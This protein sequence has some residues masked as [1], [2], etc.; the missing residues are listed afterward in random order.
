MPRR[1]SGD[2]DGKTE[3]SEV[4]RTI[5]T[6]VGSSIVSALVT[7]MVMDFL[8]PS[9]AEAQRN[10]LQV[11]GIE[12]VGFDGR[13]WGYFGLTH[14][15]TVGLWINDDRGRARI[16]VTFNNSTPGQP[17]IRIYDETPPPGPMVPST[18]IWQAP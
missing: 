4:K 7:L 3:D 13:S 9:R 8:Q 14:V 15:G 10:V 12:I 1:G 2:D 11:N 18:P 16:E 6:A 17:T 5:I